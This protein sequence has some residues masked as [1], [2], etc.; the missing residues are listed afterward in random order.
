MSK[1]LLVIAVFA[2]LIAGSAVAAPADYKV[3]GAARVV[4][5]SS[6]LTVKLL[7]VPTGKYVKNAQVYHFSAHQ[8]G[9]GPAFMQLRHSVAP[10]GND[11]YKIKLPLHIH[12]KQVEHFMIRVPGEG[13][14]IHARIELPVVK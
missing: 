7:N 3:E 8:M 11:G 12:D 6:E 5:T 4:G 13:E 10:D 14:A 2:G 9:K 1:K